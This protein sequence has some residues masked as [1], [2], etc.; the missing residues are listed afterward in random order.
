MESELIFSQLRTQEAFHAV[1]EQGNNNW[2]LIYNLSGQAYFRHSKGELRTKPGD[3]VLYL[4]GQSRYY[5]SDSLSTPYVRLYSE[6]QPRAEWHELLQ[7]PEVAPELRMLTLE[8][9]PIRQRMAQSFREAIDHMMSHR[10]RREFFAMNALEQAL[11]WCDTENPKGSSRRLDARISRALESLTQDIARPFMLSELAQRSGLSI[12]RFS[13]LFRQ[14][15]GTTPQQYVE[16][17]RLDRARQLLRITQ[18]PIKEIAMEIGY[19]DPFYFSLRFRRYTGMSPR[20][21]RKNCNK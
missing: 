12:S 18:N 21:F 2:L 3:V 15:T 16:T 11:L 1:R 19:P 17:Q 8:E 13:W 14:S 6:F 4:P 7:W 5:G 10:Q 9:E 20:Q